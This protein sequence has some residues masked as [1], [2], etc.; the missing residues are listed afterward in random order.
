MIM[1]QRL[2][3]IVDGVLDG[4]ELLGQLEAWPP[5]L[6]HGDDHVQVTVGALEALDDVGMGSVWHVAV[7]EGYPPGRIFYPRG[8][9]HL[10]WLGVALMC[11]ADV[12][13]C[14]PGIMF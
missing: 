13:D 9:Y 7:L 3:R 1:N 6:D 5:L 11:A 8:G 4:L 10:T 14:S 12:S 2:L